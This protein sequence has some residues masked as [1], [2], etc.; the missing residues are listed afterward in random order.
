MLDLGTAYA[1]L[2]VRIDRLEKNL[3]EA[4]RKFDD[5]GRKIEARG[6][7]MS[8]ELTATMGSLGRSLTVGLTAPIL[9][10]GTAAVKAAV[11]MDSL[12]RGLRAVA[13][14]SQETERQLVRLKEVAKLPGLGFQEAVRGSV[15]LQAAGL[16]AR[17]AERA[18]MG[19]GNALATVGKGKAEL[20][21]VIVALSQIQSK[22]KV[23]AEEINQLAERVPQI[24]KVMQEAFGTADTELLQKAKIGS[25]EFIE[26]ITS[27]L[28]KLPKVT[29]GAQNAFENFSDSANRA[30][31]AIG[32]T[33]LPMVTRA[34]EKLTPTLERIAENF[35][36][37]PAAAKTGLGVLF[38]TGAVVGPALLG[39]SAL[40]GAIDKIKV[41]LP[42]LI[43]LIGKLKYFIPEIP[44]SGEDIEKIA[45]KSKNPFLQNLVR[46][47][48]E[49]TYYDEMERA[50]HQG[51]ISRD[52]PMPV[53]VD[54]KIDAAIRAKR[55]EEA[56]EAARKAREFAE[57]QREARKRFDVD[58]ATFRN[59]FSGDRVE[60]EQ[61]FKEKIPLL[62]IGDATKWLQG[63]LKE[64]EKAENAERSAIK[65]AYQRRVDEFSQL[66][67]HASEERIKAQEDAAKEEERRRKE[68]MDRV[69]DQAIE[70]LKT[71]DFIRQRAEEIRQ[72]A[73]PELQ[74]WSR[75]PLS[76]ESGEPVGV[77]NRN[78]DV[79]FDNPLARPETKDQFRQRVEGIQERL[80]TSLGGILGQ[81]VAFEFADGFAR[82]LEKA[83]GHS[84]IGRILARSL[85]RFLDN[86]LQGALDRTIGGIANKIGKGGKFGIGDL[87]GSFLGPI[88]K[89]F[90]FAK[91][92]DPPVG[93]WSLVG[94]QGPEFIKPRAAMTVVPMS[95][96]GGAGNL[97]VNLGGV[98]IANDYDVDRLVDRI[99]QQAKRRLAV[100]PGTF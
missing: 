85:S 25:K 94:E 4:G 10:L 42:A 87:F 21:G 100:N 14:S 98:T 89:I 61:Q 5:L 50:R 43:P 58:M 47:K 3:A 55:A 71:E 9:G 32:N 60:A 86:F 57:Q 67:K 40:L 78:P 91:G 24:R 90:G 73:M 95:Q 54:P 56:K 49:Q 97:T 18:L 63:R 19:F 20:D 34:L 28:E 68:R 76:W 62:G 39:L 35:G 81:E 29:G 7:R 1:S 33:L 26:T 27:A 69:H 80:K 12:K 46:Q 92:G 15:N 79:P 72:R 11:D 88:G 30:L 83:F 52:R 99:S 22:G 84:S 37:L 70:A 75:D 6:K 13:G 59:K 2:D 51:M 38:T 93:R 96:M 53:R 82:S 65:A 16:S 66:E 36:K 77:G 74:D 48:D 44:M 17:T 8:A 64:I 23:S 45:R 31:T 41:A